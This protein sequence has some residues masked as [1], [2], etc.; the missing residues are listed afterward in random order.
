VPGAEAPS[1]AMSTAGPEL[2]RQTPLSL[3]LTTPEPAREPLN[4]TPPASFKRGEESKV[5]KLTPA[6]VPGACVPER[7]MVLVW[8]KAV[9]AIAVRTSTTV[10]QSEYR[11]HFANRSRVDD[12]WC[13]FM[14]L[15]AA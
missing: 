3:V 9:G 13:E 14:V 10:P 6:G 1:R 12:L 11:R 4:N 7:T 5:A 15:P 2:A 8:E